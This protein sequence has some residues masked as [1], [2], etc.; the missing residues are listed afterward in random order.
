MTSLPM[1]QKTDSMSAHNFGHSS[2]TPGL[3]QFT[4]QFASIVKTGIWT[5]E[6]DRKRFQINSWDI[7]TSDAAHLYLM[8][9]L[10]S[11]TCVTIKF[12]LQYE[13]RK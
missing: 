5:V 12:L 1:E 3:E 11:N 2:K 9:A 10:R 7:H 8:C 13:S 4:Y 6:S